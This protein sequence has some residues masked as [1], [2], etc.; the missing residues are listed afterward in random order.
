[1]TDAS[2][3]WQ[4]GDPVAA[5]CEDIETAKADV[6]RYGYCL[7][8]NAID[9]DTL[10]EARDR[11][12]T[13]AEAER[14]A[15]I[16]FAD[17]GPGQAPKRDYAV[18]APDAF[19]EAA[20]GVN[21]R[22]WMLVNKGRVF[23][24][25]VTHPKTSP[26]VESIIGPNYLLSTLSANIAKPGGL[27]MGEDIPNFQPRGVLFQSDRAEALQ[28]QALFSLTAEPRR[29]QVYDT[30]GH[31]IELLK[32]DAPRRDFVAWLADGI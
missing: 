6:A 15:N 18:V 3:P 29:V 11:L 16:A 8:A 21:Q 17:Q 13:Q 28:S 30:P 19:T 14:R 2:P 27:L 23:R 1:M 20:G 4:P 9:P 7:L 24:D 32:F 31:G 26:V 10:A 5:P 22:V 12:V 25:L